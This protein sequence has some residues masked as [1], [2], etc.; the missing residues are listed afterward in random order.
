MRKLKPINLS[1]FGAGQTIRPPGDLGYQNSWNIG[2][3]NRQY[4]QFYL[5]AAFTSKEITHFF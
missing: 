4:Y 5:P 1:N 3:Q 2:A